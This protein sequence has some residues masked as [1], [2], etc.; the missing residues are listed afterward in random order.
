MTQLTKSVILRFVR[1]FVAGAVATMAT[2]LTFSGGWKELGMWLS[3]LA[4]GAIVGGITGVI[5][6][7]DKYF[8]SADK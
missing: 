4:L 3:A 6:A 1:A 5:Q 8:R 7:L 2:T